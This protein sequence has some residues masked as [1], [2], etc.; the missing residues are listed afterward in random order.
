M[1][2]SNGSILSIA[3]SIANPDRYKVVSAGAGDVEF[4]SDWA[5]VDFGHAFD[6]YYFGKSP[7]EDPALYVRMS[8][9]FKMDRVKAPTIIFFGTEDRNVPTSQGWTHYRALYHLGKVPVKFLLF[10]GE[11]HGPRQY[12]HQLRKVEEEMELARP[13]FL[14]DAESRERGLQEGFAPRPGAPQEGRRSSRDKV[15]RRRESGRRL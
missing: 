10:P 7:L 2:W 13:V 5:N 4:I 15:R 6:T 12:A 11:A 9:L 14:Q 1:G 8:P 3:V